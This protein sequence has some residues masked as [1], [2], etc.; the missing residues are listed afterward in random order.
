LILG[1]TP[2]AF[3]QQ[4]GLIRIFNVEKGQMIKEFTLDRPP[5]FEGISASRGRL[6]I[7]TRDGKLT[8]YG[9]K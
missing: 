2:N 4:K 3:A 9:K 1:G 6:F 5:V 8:C 7:T